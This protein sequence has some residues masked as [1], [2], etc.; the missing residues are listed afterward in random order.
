MPVCWLEGRFRLDQDEEVAELSFRKG[1]LSRCG[2]L[3]ARHSWQ[4]AAFNKRYEIK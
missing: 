1:F 2:F 4:P 3:D